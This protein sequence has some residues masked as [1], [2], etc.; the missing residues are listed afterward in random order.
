MKP[1]KRAE[2]IRARYLARRP[3]ACLALPAKPKPLE[4]H[5]VPYRNFSLGLLERDYWRQDWI[6]APDAKAKTAPQ[7]ER[8][9]KGKTPLARIAAHYPVRISN[10]S[11]QD[12]PR[13]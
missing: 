7:P 4:S 12:R 1:E 5:R 6:A 13:R 8:R 10:P 9:R 2:L 3:S 11:R